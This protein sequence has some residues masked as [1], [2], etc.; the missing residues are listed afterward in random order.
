MNLTETLATLLVATTLSIP[1]AAFNDFTDSN[2][3]IT[4]DALETALNTGDLA[5]L[6]TIYTD[7]AEVIHADYNSL[8]N[9]SGPASYL[10]E[11]Y[12]IGRGRYR[13]DVI[14]LLVDDN[15][16]YL[17]ALWSATVIID[18][19]DATVHDG[20]VSN[21]LERQTDGSWKIREQRWD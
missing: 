18:A 16:A 19:N 1:V 13:I 4:I 11:Q 7:N 17:S 9:N 6:K 8:D 14:D 5:T 2:V 3:Q 15:V 10:Y 12:K 21:V 20:Y